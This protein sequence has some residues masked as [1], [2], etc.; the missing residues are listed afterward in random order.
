[1]KT[2]YAFRNMANSLSKGILLLSFFQKE[3]KK[4]AKNRSILLG[5]LLWATTTGSLFAQTAT[6]PTLGDGSASNPYR[7]A[8]LNNLYWIAENSTRWSYHYVQTASIDASATS[9]W[10]SGAGWTPIGNSSDAFGGTYDGQLYTISNLYINRSTTDYVGLF[11]LTANSL[12]Y[13]YNLA[14]IL[15]TNVDITGNDN[16][17]GICG[18]TQQY[19]VIQSC[20]CSGSITGNEKVGG[21]V[22]YN[23]ISNV[24][25]SK[26]T[27]L[28]K[29]SNKVGGFIGSSEENCYVDN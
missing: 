1:M 6:A 9:T 3:K 2:I 4:N 28:V 20:S 26:T 18:K 15:L 11:G 8:S 12:G 25:F 17:G 10:F 16:V 29:G 14:N 19:A 24:K 22:G 13:S 21:I 27:A 5:I 23:Y 7:I